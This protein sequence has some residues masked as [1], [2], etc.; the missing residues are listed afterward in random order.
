MAHDP[1]ALPSTAWYLIPV[2]RSS[3]CARPPMLHFTGGNGQSAFDAGVDAY[4]LELGVA[5]VVSAARF[6]SPDHKRIG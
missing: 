2:P 5:S 4:I 1:F 3:A 6:A